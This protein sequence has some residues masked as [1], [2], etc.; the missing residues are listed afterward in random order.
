MIGS[1]KEVILL[2]IGVL[3]FSS[4]VWA[5]H[6][7]TNAVDGG[8][9][10]SYNE[11][12]SIRIN[13]SVQNSDP[14]Q[15]ANISEVNI[16][17]ST[18][19]SI[20]ADTNYTDTGNHI[21]VYSTTS[22]SW[23]NFTQF[24]VNGSTTKTFLFNLTANFPGYYNITITTQNTTNVT[25][26]KLTIQIN[27][28]TT[29]SSIEFESPTPGNGT[30]WVKNNIEFNVSARDNYAVNSITLEVYNSTWNRINI[31]SSGLNVTAYYLNFTNYTYG[32]YFINASV[33]D[34]TGRI[35][36]SSTRTI[37]LDGT[38]P[39][40]ITF[41]SPTMGNGTGLVRNNMEINISFADSIRINSVWIEVYN[42]TFN[43]VNSTLS[44]TNASNYYLN[45]TNYTWGT[46]YI[47]ASVNDTAGNVNS[48][49]VRTV[50]LDGARPNTIEFGSG[51]PANGAN[52]SQSNIL[53]N[54]TFSDAI[55]MNSILLEVF[56]STGR[57]NLS[58]SATNASS[59]SLNFSYLADGTYYIN[60]TVNDSAGNTNSTVATRTV[61]LDRTAPS[62]SL[63]RSSSSTTSSIVV[64]VAISD[65]T[66]GIGTTCT[67]DR[68][69]AGISGTTT[70]QTLTETGLTCG[71]SYTFGVTCT[72]RA[73][74]T[75]SNSIT[76]STEACSGE[77][78][79]GGGGS[80]STTTWDNTY[81]AGTESLK[82]GYTKSLKARERVKLDLAGKTHYVGVTAISATSATLSVE[83]TPKALALNVGETKKV[84][85]DDNGV[86]DISLELVSIDAGKAKIK[87]ASVEEAIEKA[88]EGG[89]E[90]GTGLPPV[91]E[92]AEEEAGIS[93]ST[94]VL[95]VVLVV[96][97][98]A[99]VLWLMKKKR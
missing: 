17:V 62:V 83:S 18:G 98:L 6:V 53:F 59:Y 2:L 85:V 45:F 22:L 25:M 24:I 9:F 30:G 7:V 94:I 72:D 28:T 26:T 32:I 33:N 55:M 96:V 79:G 73:G 54:V 95:I 39:S 20:I 70:S 90:G 76:A 34:T 40:D 68:G 78:A 65:A 61:K 91:E 46:Y 81:V 64:D 16:S 15:I 88:E 3:I 29:P 82:G 60:A 8:T 49:G 42:S 92:A 48:T 71:A 99:L 36:V 5:S 86:Y 50:Y 75:G 11:D 69:N 27:D 58:I 51:S 35:N 4:F 44:T 12:T 84:D 63:T 74:N 47:N 89:I 67:A 37:Y 31:S 56:N 23:Q 87:I 14:N 21:L 93:T 41:Q 43:R 66:S 38:I 1:K 13:I 10:F 57:Q 19:L 97:L 52:L 77:S 80:G